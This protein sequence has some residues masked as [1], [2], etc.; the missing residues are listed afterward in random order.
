MPLT[1]LA[2]LRAQV[3]G[4]RLCPRLARHREAVAKNPPPRYQG[5]RYWARPLPGFGDREARLLIV[6][7]APAAHGGNRTGRMFTGD[8]SGQWLARALH[9]TGFASQPTSTHVGDG[10]ALTGA[11]ITAAVR[12]APP[13]NKP[14]S[15][16]MARCQPYLETEL[17]LLKR[18][19]VVVALGRVAFEAFLRSREAVGHP[20]LKKKPRF[21]HGADVQLPEGITLISS[22]HPSQQNTFTGKLTRPML[23]RVFSR[24]RRIL[25]LSR[26]SG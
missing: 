4:C 7:L 6:G 10:F 23:S 3:I 20:G 18:V 16:E 26:R 13:G 9:E 17:R 11:Y 5:Q 8:G 12:C 24:A 25:T 2:A 21:A 1:S 22:Y 19:S 14:T 15:R